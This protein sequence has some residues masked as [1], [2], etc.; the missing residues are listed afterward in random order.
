MS[1]EAFI[2]NNEKEVRMAFFFGVL[3]IMA[4]WEIA[5]PRRSLTVSKAL[6]WTNNLALVFFNAWLLRLVFPAAAIGVTLAAQANG[7]GLFNVYP[8]S[9]WLA[10]PVSIVILD[11]VIYLQHVMVHAVP[12]LWRLHRMHHT[13]NDLDVTSG[14]RLHP[15]EILLSMLFKFAVTG[16]RSHAHVLEGTAEPAQFVSLEMGNGNQRIGIDDFRTDINGFKVLLADVDTG[17]APAPHAIRDDD[18]CLNH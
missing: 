9:P 1:L 12:L 18:G 7:W 10:V 6:R 8:V 2:V 17:L 15:L 14:T 16:G 11:L 4:I 13:D 5:A 3:L